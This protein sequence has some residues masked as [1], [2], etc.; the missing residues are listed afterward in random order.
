MRG[1]LTGVSYVFLALVAYGFSSMMALAHEAHSP[2]GASW[3][4]DGYCCNGDSQT[5]DCQ[6]IPDK[7]VKIIQGG[8]EII[9]GPGDHRLITRKHDFKL[10]QSEARR[11]LDSQYHI[12]LYP[13]E[14]TLRCFY[15]PDMSY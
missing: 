9:I 12:C 5:G 15:A 2:T 1:I 11:S 8:Y 3:K 7:N 4:Y 13:D 6:M 10:P 14:N